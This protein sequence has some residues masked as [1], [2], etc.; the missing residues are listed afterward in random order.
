MARFAVTGGCGFVGSHLVDALIARG[1]RV[2]VL[3]DLSAG[4][5]EN[6]NPEAELDVGSVTDADAVRR[7]VAGCDG[8]FHLAA[9]ASVQRCNEAWRDSHLVN[10]AGSVTVLEAA[11]DVGR[12]PV[13]YASSAAVYGDNANTP[14]KETEP[15]RPLT[16][17]GVDKYGSELHAGVAGR[18]HGVP[19]FG[20][21]FF[22]VFG[23]RQDPS[24]PYSGVISIFAAR[25]AV[26]RDITIHGDGG[27]TRDFVHVDDV[28]GHL[29]SGMTAADVAAPVANVC[30][31]TGT[32]VLQLAEALRLL[33]GYRGAIGH[34]PA[35]AGDIRISVGDPSFAISRLK[36]RATVGLQEGLSGLLANGAR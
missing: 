12:I 33:T 16:A 3:D 30:T 28:A 13:V 20:L 4:K 6:L 18:I 31:G 14:L 26:G 9:V 1:D 29:L 24:S 8:V 7:V 25:M 11:R 36:R 10:L 17:Y 35:R 5:C 34:G 32:S 22:N 21:R 2:R 15:P 19:S 27:Q 23:P